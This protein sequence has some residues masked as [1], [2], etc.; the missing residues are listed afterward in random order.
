M[1]IAVTGW[2][3]ILAIK[4]LSH[5]KQAPV[6]IVITY[7]SNSRFIDQNTL[8]RISEI[9]R[10][11]QSLSKKGKIT[12]ITVLFLPVYYVYNCN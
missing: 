4:V 7:Y 6:Y 11:K 3:R 9:E 10:K 8:Q 1:S 2:G 5:Y 12:S